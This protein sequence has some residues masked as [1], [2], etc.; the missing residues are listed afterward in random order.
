MFHV[1]CDTGEKLD[2]GLIKYG[3]L[4][5]GDRTEWKT[6]RIAE[7]HARDYK[8]DHLRDAWVEES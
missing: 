4:S 5:V 7:R 2:D 1:V 3:I 6:K 8:A